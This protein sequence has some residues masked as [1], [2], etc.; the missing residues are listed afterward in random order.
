MH[1]R[2]ACESESGVDIVEATSTQAL[3]NFETIAGTLVGFW[4]PAD[5]K[6]NAIAGY[7]MHFIS[8]DRKHGAMFSTSTR[9]S[10]RLLPQPLT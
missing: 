8:A 5:T 4:S 6:L 2:T 7:H 9:S 3:F 10:Q 1:L